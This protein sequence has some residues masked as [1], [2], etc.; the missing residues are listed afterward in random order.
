MKYASNVTELI[1]NTPLLALD[2]DPRPDGSLV[3]RSYAQIVA[4]PRGGEP[5]VHLMCETHD[6][7]V[8]EGG[9]LVVKNRRVTRDDQD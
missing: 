6:V 3:V 9:A 2:V 1:G 4:T 8:R 7:L 5:R